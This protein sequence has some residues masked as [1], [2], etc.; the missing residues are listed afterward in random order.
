MDYIDLPEF[1]IPHEHKLANYEKNNENIAYYNDGL[2]IDVSPR[3]PE[4]PL[5]DDRG[6]AYDARY[7][8]ING[9][10]YD[11]YNS[12]EILSIPMFE[13]IDRGPEKVALEITEDYGIL[14]EPVTIRFLEPRSPTL[15][16]D[17]HIQMRIKGSFSPELTVPLIY[18]YSNLRI[19]MFMLLGWDEPLSFD[20]RLLYQ[21]LA[22][23]EDAH[24][25]YLVEEFNKRNIELYSKDLMSIEFYRELGEKNM[26]YEWIRRNIPDYSPK[27]IGAYTTMKNKKTKR[28]M[29]IKEEALRLGRVLK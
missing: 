12:A 4:V 2:L 24:Y 26:E 7:I 23:K 1:Y 3:N 14:E 25:H 17:Y 6:I 21:L 10:S 22:V 18:F 16:L 9:R 5:Y 13:Q 20:M 28:Y 19:N 8:V 15:D 27:T 29:K 11:L